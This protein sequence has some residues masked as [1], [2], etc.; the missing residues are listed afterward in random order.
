MTRLRLGTRGSPLALWQAHHVRDRLAALHPALEIEIV[1]ITTTGDR[2]L[3]QP[4]P[5]IGAEGLFTKEVEEALLDGRIDAA[6]HSC[7]DVPTQLPAGLALA[8]ILERVH[9]GDVLISKARATLAELPSASVLATGSLRRRAQLL[10]Y[11]PD[12][13]IVNLRGNLNTRFRKFHASDWAGMILAEAG[14]V[15][16]A[17][18]HEITERISTDVLLPAVGQ[19]ALALEARADDGGT[20]RLVAPLQHAETADAVAAERAFLHHLRG[21]CQVPVGALATVAGERLRLQGVIASLDGKSLCR[22]A[23]EG[24]RTQAQQ[25][26]VALAEQLLARGARA[27]LDAIRAV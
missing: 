26:G 27:I 5:E 7:K 21:G 6:V 10:H 25:V 19:G 3:S 4:L 2:N 23:L 12:L 9:G 24:A 20:R 15:R 18:Q 17:M 11:R 16:L 22:G 8:A 1:E 14:V 13:S